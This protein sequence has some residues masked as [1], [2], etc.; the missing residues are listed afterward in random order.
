MYGLDPHTGALS[1]DWPAA[2][3]DIGLPNPAQNDAIGGGVFAT[4][5]PIIYKN[6]IITAGASGFLPPPAQP[7]DPHANDLRTGRLV[8]TARLIPPGDA[9]WGPQTQ[10]VVGSGSWGILS[11]DDKTGT[12]YV[13]TD[14]GSPDYVG[15]WR[16]GDN[17][18]ADA[19]V[20]IDAQTGAVKW[21]FQ[22]HRH[23]VFDLDTMAAPSPV[24]IKKNGRKTKVIVQTTKQGMIWV[25]DAQSGKP[26]LPYEER[27]VAQ[28][29]IAGERTAATQPFTVSPPP[30]SDG[31]VQ[32]DHLSTLS[33]RANAECK[34]L[35]DA[36]QLA[37]AGPFNP[38]RPG[39]AW[40]LMPI[41]A[42]GGIDWGGASID[43]DH[44]TAIA[45][46]TNLPTMITV[47][48]GAGIPGN[49][50]LRSG[51]GNVR[52]MDKDG[53]S[54]NGGRQGELVSV[55]LATGKLAWRVPLGTLEDDYGPQVR[56]MGAT[57]IGPSLVTHGGLVFIGAATDGRFHIYDSRSGKLLWQMKMSASANAGPMTYMGK[58]GRQYVV[59][60]A[61]GPGNARRPSERE[62]LL[63]HQT[64]VAFALPRPGE[65]PIDIVTPY[66]ARTPQPGESLAIDSAGNASIVVPRR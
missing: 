18:G 16:P 34:A 50:G 19:T 35:F 3:L 62:N 59:I 17:Q 2:G 12:V 60:A 55:D 43:F 54:C 8:W 26:A 52:F 56:D 57:N 65:A 28:S 49:G 4:S 63:Y 61:G 15:V 33:E 42:T 7:A 44:G 64:M 40:T 45:N 9:S 27:P 37:D 31:V 36:N 1:T 30:L 39:G 22:N 38:P 23:D 46:V 25:L 32:R 66:P 48:P 11:L 10:N 53:R 47:T 14:S 6:L 58:D 5:P 41:G 21:S 51:S 29:A 13:P 24:E 20:A